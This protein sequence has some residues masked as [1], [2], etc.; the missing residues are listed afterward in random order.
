MFELMYL[1][2][3]IPNASILRNNMKQHKKIHSCKT[4]I[5][6][7]SLMMYFVIFFKSVSVGYAVLCIPFCR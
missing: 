2:F 7:D 4:N 6:Q 3:R 5:V 1:C